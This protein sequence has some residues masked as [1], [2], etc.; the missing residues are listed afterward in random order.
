MTVASSARGSR[1]IRE[2]VRA[3]RRRASSCCSGPQ[4]DRD[5]QVKDLREPSVSPGSTSR[6]PT[7]FLEEICRRGSGAAARGRAAPGHR[8]RSVRVRQRHLDQPRPVALSIAALEVMG[9]RNL[10]GA[11]AACPSTWCR[12]GRNECS[13]PLVGQSRRS[14]I[15]RS[16][17]GALDS[18]CRAPPKPRRTDE[19]CG[20]SSRMT[21]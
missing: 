20:S 17:S 21:L 15:C 12:P 14:G 8:A 10:S 18:G 19:R 5:S 11:Q 4:P 1:A 6:M 2:L 13:E 3:P 9:R 7:S 16:A